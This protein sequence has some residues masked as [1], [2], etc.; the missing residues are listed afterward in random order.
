MA[1][2]AIG[3]VRVA[4]TEAGRCRTALCAWHAVAI[5]MS[6]NPLI[7]FPHPTCP[8]ALPDIPVINVPLSL[9][10]STQSPDQP[11]LSVPLSRHTQCVSSGPSSPSQSLLPSP[12]PLPC[13]PL[14][15]LPR[16][17]IADP[18]SHRL[19]RSYVFRHDLAPRTYLSYPSPDSRS[20]VD[21]LTESPAAERALPSGTLSSRCV[22][23][24]LLCFTLAHS[25]A[26]VFR[27]T[28]LALIKLA[29]A[30]RHFLSMVS[31]GALW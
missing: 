23:S 2:A 12:R 3:R 21:A 30:I 8:A 17:P 14:P 6:D 15:A 31:T 26:P 11:P 20:R 5:L 10:L 27:N 18:A 28:A 19:T 4:W 25:L 9:Q 7:A 1:L 13:V 22:A 29:I 24:R 16:V